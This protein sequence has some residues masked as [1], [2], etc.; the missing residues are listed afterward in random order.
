MSHQLFKTTFDEFI[1]ERLDNIRYSQIET[2]E[3]IKGTFIKYIKPV[4][5]PNN[6]VTLLFAKAKKEYSFQQ[7]QELADWILFIKSMYPTYLKGASPEYYNTIAQ[8]SYYNC[9][10]IVNGEWKLF[11]ELSDNLPYFIKCLNKNIK[12]AYFNKDSNLRM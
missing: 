6:N 2:K 12:K 9:Y 7:F 3:Y 8:L 4:N 5:I 1:T 10:K 11:E